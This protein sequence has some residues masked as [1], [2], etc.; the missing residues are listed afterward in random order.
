MP[1]SDRRG[2]APEVPVGEAFERRMRGLY[3]ESE[4]NNDAS[5]VT[6][7]HIKRAILRGLQGQD[8]PF[9]DGN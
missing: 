5:P 2:P 8:H 4:M 6:N 3:I 9:Y 7:V 1:Q